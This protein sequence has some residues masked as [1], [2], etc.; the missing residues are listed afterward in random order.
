MSDVKEQRKIRMVEALACRNAGERLYAK[1]LQRLGK[2]TILQHM[3]DQLK[4]LPC[5]K[6]L[7]ESGLSELSIVLGISEGID[8]L[9]YQRIAQENDLRFIVGSERDVQ[10]RLLQCAH[11]A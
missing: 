5:L 1:P 2:K 7:Q 8:N 3:I 11:L 9:I 4:N 6:E 10:F